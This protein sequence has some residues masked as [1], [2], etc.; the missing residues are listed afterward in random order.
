[1]QSVTVEERA[2]SSRRAGRSLLRPRK[3][4]GRP[5]PD[6]DLGLVLE[7]RDKYNTSR[8]LPGAGRHPAGP[9]RLGR[10]RALASEAELGRE[11]GVS[12]VTVRRALELLRDEGLVTAR[13]GVGWFVAVDP[14]RQSLGRVTTV[15]AALEAAGAA[16]GRRVLEFAFE[17]APGGRRQDARTCRPTAR[18]CG[19]RGST[20][21]TASRSRSSPSGSPPTLGAAPEPGRRRA[22]DVLRPAA[23]PGR[24]ARSGG[25]DD[26]RDRRRARRPAA[27]SACPSARRCW[28]AGGSPT[29][30]TETRSSSRSTATR[31]TS[32]RSK[33]NSPPPQ[34]P[35]ARHA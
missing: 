23:A 30:A 9:D 32:P 8:A 4:L 2:R 35:G 1:M 11:Y 21:P 20:W 29:I 27:S 31:P 12:R 26:H 15:E 24:R 7:R 28:P 19:S 34:T 33:S 17:P 14:V 25:A 3:R 18:C 22:L 13:Q 16:S 5:G 10:P 6:R